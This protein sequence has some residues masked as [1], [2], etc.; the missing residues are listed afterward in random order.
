MLRLFGFERQWLVGVLED[1]VPGTREVPLRRFVDDLLA[2]APL[3]FV[4]GLRACLWLLVLSPPFLLRRMKSYFGLSF[5][6]RL[7]VHARLKSSSSYVIREMPLLFKML[8]CL[9]YCGLP[10]VQAEIGITPRDSEPA[11]WARP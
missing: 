1:V 9:G 4:A 11:E 10:E 7:A 3:E 2:H 8:G 5:E 6:E